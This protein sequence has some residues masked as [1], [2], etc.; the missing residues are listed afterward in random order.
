VKA[1]TWKAIFAGMNPSSVFA[2][3]ADFAGA[4]SDQR[5]RLPLKKTDASA[6]E[7]KRL[8]AEHGVA[9]GK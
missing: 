4:M 2:A 5:R 8:G 6:A 3:I 1:V 7:T 9:C